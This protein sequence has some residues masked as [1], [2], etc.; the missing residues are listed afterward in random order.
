MSRWKSNVPPVPSSTSGEAHSDDPHS[1]IY[2]TPIFNKFPSYGDTIPS[3][4]RY[5]MSHL[6]FFIRVTPQ[7]TLRS[8]YVSILTI[9]RH[10][11]PIDILMKLNLYATE[12]FYKSSIIK[13]TSYLD[14]DHPPRIWSTT[15]GECTFNALSVRLT[16]ADK[17][18]VT[19]GADGHVAP[20]Y[21][22][23]PTTTP[24]PH[25]STTK[26]QSSYNYQYHKESGIVIKDV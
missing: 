13:L 26:A 4:Y 19:V 5:Y 9:L 25:G 24:K 7:T 10:H 3:Y 15:R 6:S 23:Q 11:I 1:L 14:S 22:E 16:S 12:N 2:M 21:T 17:F 8:L 20:R 18:G